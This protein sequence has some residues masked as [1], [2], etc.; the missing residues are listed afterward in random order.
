VDLACELHLGLPDVL[1]QCFELVPGDGGQLRQVL[2]VVNAGPEVVDAS[3]EG[4]E[5]GA[6][7]N[8]RGLKR[9]PGSSCYVLKYVSICQL[10][11]ACDSIGL[12]TYL[13]VVQHRCG[14]SLRVWVG[15]GGRGMC[16]TR[17]G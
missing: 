16:S 4:A 1:A 6:A 3:S 12:S 17:I 13:A 9:E 7:G 15:V 2:T 11:Y 14:R 5:Y 8:G 10:G